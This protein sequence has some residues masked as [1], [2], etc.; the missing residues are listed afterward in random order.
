MENL[1]CE[2]CSD[3][4]KMIGVDKAVCSFCGAEFKLA[5]STGIFV[6]TKPNTRKTQDPILESATKAYI[7]RL[8]SILKYIT[9]M[10]KLFQDWV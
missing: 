3:E 7:S 10:K 4:L 2:I 6:E 5:E 9:K 1:T 8:I